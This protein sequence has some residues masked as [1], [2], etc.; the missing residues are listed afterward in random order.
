M[1]TIAIS[2]QKGGCGKTTT[3][4]NLAAAFS[5]I[6][7]RTLVIDMDAQAHASL[8]LGLVPDS[9]DHSIYEMLVNDETSSLQ[10]IQRT[11]LPNLDI[12][13]SNILLSGAEI[14]LCDRSGREFILSSKLEEIDRFYDL[15]IIDCSPSLSVLALNSLVAS[16]YVLVP[17][18]THY[19]AIEGLKQLIDTIEQVQL[20]FNPSLQILGILLTFYES[21]TLLS[22]DVM[23][24][25]REYFGSLVFDT[26]IHR[27]VRLAEAP[28]AG[29]SVLTYAPQNSGAIE[30]MD[31]AQEIENEKIRNEQEDI[32]NI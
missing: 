18:Q 12:I 6:G 32:V 23:Q 5:K 11:Y 7:K 25:M 3:S 29:E 31:L 20:R 2:N 27:T 4:V 28:S 9:Y 16:D 30:Y 13:P 14:E 10:A 17:V 22:R 8:G 15:C 19:Y 26:V 21:R 1:K 24:Q